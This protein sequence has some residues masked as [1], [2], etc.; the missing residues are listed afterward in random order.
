M[1]NGRKIFGIIFLLLII[2]GYIT[3]IYFLEKEK[4]NAKPEIIVSGDR[5]V[6]SVEDEE[7]KLLEGIKAYDRE[8]GDLTK[9]VIVDS[10]SPFNK[11]K[12][13]TV[14]YIVFDRENQIA[15][16]ER[17]IVYTDYTEPK[18]TLN[19]PLVLNTMS[20]TKINKLIGASSS[21]DG[22]ISNRVLVKIGVLDG[23]SFDVDVSVSDST[24]TQVMQ[25]FRCEYNRNIYMAEIAL[26]EYFVSLPAGSQYDFAANIKEIAIGNGVKNELIPFVNIQNNV[27]YNVPGVYE[28]LYY[29]DAGNGNT[30]YT[31]CIVRIE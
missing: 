14:K 1:K 25:K 9:E 4:D 27:D 10:V 19:G 24:G 20:A 30:G 31:K 6:L 2:A 15:E 11:E 22:D 26:K 5:P 29:L 21:V 13:R 16:A 23:F 7:S 8:D 28:V 3:A 17:K 12:E 18:I